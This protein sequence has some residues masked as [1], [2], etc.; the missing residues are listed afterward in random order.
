MRTRFFSIIGIFVLLAGT[1]A[2]QE[3]VAVF[4][5]EAIGIDQEQAA[6][7][8]QLFRGE[9]GATGKFTVIP[10]GDVEA[11]LAEKGITDFSCHAFGCASEYALIAGVDKAVIGTL[12]MFGQRVT[13]EVSLV[14]AANKQLEFNDRFATISIDDLDSV[15]RK[16]AQAVA[17]RKKIE[18]EVGRFAVTQE[19]TVEGR[20]K[21]SY[22]TT[23]AAFGF[24]FPLGDSSYRGH[25]P[26]QAPRL[27]RP[28]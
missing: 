9:L 23:G 24:G 11:K 21:T 6:I 3:R 18:S 1:V 17:D 27:R 12:T 2:A 5:F 28:L 19:E 4:E 14:S 22:I 25:R 20:R 15:L 26:S 16:L 7:A 8:T 10:K 13:V